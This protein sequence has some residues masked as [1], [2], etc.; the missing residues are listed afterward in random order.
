MPLVLPGRRVGIGHVGLDAL[1]QRWILQ[2]GDHRLFRAF[3]DPEREASVEAVRRADSLRILVRRD[4]KAT[5]R[6]GVQATQHLRHLSPFRP[7]CRL[8][9]KDFRWDA[10]A[11]GDREDFIGDSESAGLRSLVGDVNPA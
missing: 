8:Q 6:R 7:I 1:A 10:R 2:P 4:V 3:A 11:L 9:M 5:R